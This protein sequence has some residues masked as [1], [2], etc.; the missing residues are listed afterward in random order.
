MLSDFQQTLNKHQTISLMPY[1]GVNLH[2]NL[3]DYIYSSGY[4]TKLNNEGLLLIGP[5]LRS[6]FQIVHSVVY[7]FGIRFKPDAFSYFY[8]YDSLDQI[9]NVFHEFP[10]KKFPDIKLLLRDFSN[11]LDRFF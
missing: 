1:G 4:E 5:H 7:G 9:V 11:C 8:N 3:G 2:V 10:R 6:D